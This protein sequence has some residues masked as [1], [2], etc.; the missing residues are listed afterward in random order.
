MTDPNIALDFLNSP[1]L[2]ILFDHW[3]PW[4]NNK[5]LNAIIVRDIAY[6]S[7]KSHKPTETLNQYKWLRNKVTNLINFAKWCKYGRY[8]WSGRQKLK[9][10]NVVSSFKNVSLQIVFFYF[11]FFAQKL[12]PGCATDSQWWCPFFVMYSIWVVVIPKNFQIHGEM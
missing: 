6:K 3:V 10:E 7:C 8:A 1:S 11:N 4:F 12:N 5:I 2:I 9:F